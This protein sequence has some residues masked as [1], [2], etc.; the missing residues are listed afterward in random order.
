MEQMFSRNY[1][2]MVVVGRKSNPNL[3]MTAD[4]AMLLLICIK[5]NSAQL[6]IMLLPRHLKPFL[7]SFHWKWKTASCFCRLWN[8]G[9]EC[10]VRPLPKEPALFWLASSRK[11]PLSSDPPNYIN[12]LNTLVL[13]SKMS[14]SQ[15][16]LYM[17]EPKYEWTMQTA[18]G[19]TLATKATE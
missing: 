13:Y 19:K 4:S 5:L 12:T 16:H 8:F 10:T 14:S 6:G 9:C 7:T 11:L 17:F 2:I 18:H 3:Q 15:I 1:S